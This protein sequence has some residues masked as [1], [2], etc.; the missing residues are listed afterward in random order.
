[1]KDILERALNLIRKTGDKVIIVD[2]GDESA[3]VVMGL[4][5]YENIA[6]TEKGRDLTEEKVPDKIDK[7]NQDIALWRE[8]TKKE[9]TEPPAVLPV[10]EKPAEEENQ[11]YFEPVE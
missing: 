2:P 4:D 8:E 5:D 11:F 6:G 1:M 7:I 3:Y 9:E 10:E